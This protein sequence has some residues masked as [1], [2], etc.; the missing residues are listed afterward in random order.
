MIEA[1][2]S[3]CL[4]MYD[5]D[6]FNLNF[7][8]FQN[9]FREAGCLVLLTKLINH[10]RSAVK[11]AAITTLGNMVLNRDNQRELRVRSV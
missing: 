11:L 6:I 1:I 5:P 10:H 8:I 3:Y 4:S 2:L 9:T 7:V